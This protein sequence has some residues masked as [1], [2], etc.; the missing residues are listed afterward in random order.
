MY[1]CYLAN[2]GWFLEG[3]FNSVKEAVDFGRSK[4][5]EFIVYKDKE[6]IGHCCGVA[7]QWFVVNS[8]FGDLQ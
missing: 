3:Q 1:R 8:D 5:Y 2:F 4:G 6:I 7:L